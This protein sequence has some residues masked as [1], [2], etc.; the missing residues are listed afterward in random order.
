MIKTLI[1]LTKN[2]MEILRAIYEKKETHLLELSN[3][4][5]L[6]PFSVQ[7]TLIKLKYILKEKKAGRTVILSINKELI[8]Y[9]QLCCL[10]EDYKLGTNDTTLRLLIKNLQEFFLEDNNI[11]SC[12]IFGS[13]ARGTHERESDIDILIIVK[14]KFREIYTKCSHISSILNRKIN[15]MLM[16]EKE[17]TTAIKS[18][19]PA[20]VSILEPSQRLIAIGKE[21]FLRKTAKIRLS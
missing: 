9:L 4:L 8:E 5:K 18:G 12:I 20:M 15:P 6:H 21:Y 19:E 2:K 11:L 17:F 14:S 13:F 10:I 3:Q 1:P 7:K 16:N